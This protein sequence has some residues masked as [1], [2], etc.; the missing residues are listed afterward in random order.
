[1][2]RARHRST[3]PPR[4]AG[5][6]PVLGVGSAASFAT[7]HLVAGALL[8]EL[9]FFVDCLDGKLARLRGTSSPRGAFFDFA[10]DVTLI[11]ATVAALGWH[12]VE[13]RGVPAALPLTV[14][15]L[16]LVTLWLVLFDSTVP[17]PA[18]SPGRGGGRSRV[19]TFLSSRRLASAPWTIE[20]ET[21]LLFLAPLTGSVGVIHGVMG[22][23]AVY[24]ALASARLAAIIYR[25][26]PAG[27]EAR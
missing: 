18:G 7:G 25:R 15:V 22:L 19:G 11:G 2:D 24:Y 13:R 21:L 1:V 26:L 10:C 6:P 27:P 12:L 16:A 4:A 8:Y 14:L 5:A 3:G 20:A 23:V 17:R 9:R